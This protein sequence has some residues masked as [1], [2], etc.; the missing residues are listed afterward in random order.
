[1]DSPS[2]PI[3]NNFAW[4]SRARSK[5]SSRGRKRKL[6]EPKIQEYEHV[7]RLGRGLF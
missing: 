3:V 6:A 1:M 4:K 5:D 2:R 7:S